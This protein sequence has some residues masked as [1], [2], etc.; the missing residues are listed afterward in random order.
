MCLEL[1]NRYLH[2]ECQLFAITTSAN[3]LHDFSYT[4]VNPPLGHLQIFAIDL[5][6]N[7]TVDKAKNTFRL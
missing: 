4:C 7:K 2:T 3:K 6:E 1:K 5:S